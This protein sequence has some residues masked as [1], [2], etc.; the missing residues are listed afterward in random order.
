MSRSKVKSSIF[1]RPFDFVLFLFFSL[2]SIVSVMNCPQFLFGLNQTFGPTLRETVQDTRDP[3]LNLAL[4]INGPPGWIKGIM[5]GELFFQLPFFIFACYK[6]WKD[7]PF[8]VLALVYSTHALTAI[9]PVLA[10]V[11]TEKG[12]FDDFVMWNSM[13]SPFWIIPGLLF[14]RSIRFI[15]IK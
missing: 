15:K 12:T 8:H 10:F 14:I 11:N 6:L 13:Y 1:K 3:V 7:E 2:H 4:D 9:L 5:A